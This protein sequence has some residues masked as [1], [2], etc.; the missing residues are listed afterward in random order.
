MISVEI[1]EFLIILT[2]PNSSINLGYL[3]WLDESIQTSA[4]CSS[5]GSYV[6]LSFLMILNVKFSEVPTTHRQIELI[7]DYISWIQQQNHQPLKN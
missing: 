3:P 6:I 4:Q 7:T 1:F 2:Y 5:E